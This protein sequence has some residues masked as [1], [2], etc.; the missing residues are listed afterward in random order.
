MARKKIIPEEE[1]PETAVV[2]ETEVTDTGEAVQSGLRPML[3][4][5]EPA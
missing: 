5:W 2:D 1:V 3:T 4:R